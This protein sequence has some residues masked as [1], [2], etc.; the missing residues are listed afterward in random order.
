MLLLMQGCVYFNDD[1]IST[2]RYRDCVE[3]Y[4]AQGIYHCECDKNL[5]DYDELPDKLLK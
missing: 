4:D 3:Y 5:A 2:H 1:G